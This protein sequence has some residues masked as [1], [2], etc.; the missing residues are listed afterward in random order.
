M[1]N[2]SFLFIGIFVNSLCLIL[3]RFKEDYKIAFISFCLKAL[4]CC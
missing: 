2:S 1:F 3:K 4:E